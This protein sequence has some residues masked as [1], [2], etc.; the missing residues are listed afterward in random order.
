MQP[1]DVNILSSE[2]RVNLDENSVRKIQYSKSVDEKK[3]CD[4]AAPSKNSNSH[5]EVEHKMKIDH[6]C[7]AL[8]SSPISLRDTACLIQGS[9]VGAGYIPLFKN[10]SESARLAGFG[11]IDFS[12]S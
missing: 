5:D 10:E 9:N 7:C 6:T 8:D 12:I 4:Y 1:P 2:M 11:I 3:E